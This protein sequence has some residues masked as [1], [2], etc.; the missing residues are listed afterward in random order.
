MK[1]AMEADAGSLRLPVPFFDLFLVL[2]VCF[3]LFLSPLPQAGIEAGDVQIPI[4]STAAKAEPGM[5]LAS[6]VQRN[7]EAWQFEPVGT[8]RRLDA[9]ALAAEARSSGRKIVLVLPATTTLQDYVA[10]QAGL[11]AQGIE[12]GIAVRNGET[13]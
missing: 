7:G 5:I 4:A 11:G 1:N 8:G 12:Y 13:K 6:F 10:L 2:L 3:M 9:S